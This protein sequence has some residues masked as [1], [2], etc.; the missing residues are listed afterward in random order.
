MTGNSAWVLV[1]GLLGAALAA[2]GVARWKRVRATVPN[3]ERLLISR[4]PGSARGGV[5]TVLVLAAAL[6]GILAT[7]LPGIASRGTSAL[8]G[9]IGAYLLLVAL[10]VACILVP[11]VIMGQ[12]RE[13]F[14]RRV[15][16]VPAL[17]AAVER[18]LA[19]WRDP[20]GNTSY[21]PL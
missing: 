21:G 8:V 20:H 10:L 12:A 6:G 14:R 5:M 4:G 7:G 11:A 1:L 19:T 15:Q 13:S 18:D 9:V 2:L 17:R 3:T 16:T